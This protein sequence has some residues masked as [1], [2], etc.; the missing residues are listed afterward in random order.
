MDQSAEGQSLE[1]LERDVLPQIVAEEIGKRRFTVTEAGAALSAALETL[2]SVADDWRRISSARPSNEEELSGTW[3]RATALTHKLASGMAAFASGLPTDEYVELYEAFLLALDALTSKWA[4]ELSA[5]AFRVLEQDDEMNVKLD[6][7]RQARR[8]F[9]RFW[10]LFQTTFRQMELE[11]P[12]MIA[13]LQL[14]PE[15][16]A[17]IEKRDWHTE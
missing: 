17:V 4:A 16:R 2:G 12:E 15:P 6:E 3:R 1:E 7:A 10:R 5:M 11:H 13:A 8:A 14:S 9:Y